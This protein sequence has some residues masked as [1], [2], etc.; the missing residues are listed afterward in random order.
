MDA[1]IIAAP[2]GRVALSASAGC[3]AGIEF[4]PDC[5]GEQAASS[6]ALEAAVFQLRRYFDDPAIP[7]SLPLRLTG[8]DYQ[9]RVW[10]ALAGIPPGRAETYG[11][12]ALR[13][14]SGPRA[15]A[16]ACR[17]NA[18]PI[19]IPCHRVVS[20]HGLGG[21]CGGMS[22]PSLDIKRWLLQHEGCAF[23]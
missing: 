22:G 3:L 4:L 6:P 1:A 8:T 16:G 7:F 5:G 10:D 2:F 21:Y 11:G 23:G 18:F 19:L 13:L 20:A 17:A 14:A 12:L 9:R 15:V